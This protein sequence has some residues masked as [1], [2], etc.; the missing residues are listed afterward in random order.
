MAIKSYL[1]R[2]DQCHLASLSILQQIIMKK[3]LY[4]F[5][6]LAMI[7]CHAEEI[8]EEAIN[9]IYDL[10]E[11]EILSKGACI[12][13]GVIFLHGTSKVIGSEA[14]AEE[15][16]EL[17]GL[18]RIYALLEEKVNWKN[19]QLGPNFRH[20][21]FENWRL[22]MN[23]KAIVNNRMELASYKDN[24]KWHY[25]SCYYVKDVEFS[26]Y[27]TGITIDSMMMDFR[28]KF[29]K[30][31]SLYYY[32]LAHSDLNEEWRTKLFHNMQTQLGK[33]FARMFFG[34]EIE[35]TSSDHITKTLDA[36]KKLQDTSSFFEM[37]NVAN[38]L[39]YNKKVCEL[40]S[41]KLLRQELPVCAEVI[42][43]CGKTDIEILPPQPPKPPQPP[44]QQAPQPLQQQPPQPQPFP[45]PPEGGASARRAQAKRH[46]G[47][48]RSESSSSHAG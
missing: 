39:P 30:V 46:R 42:R 16:A 34:M 29:D 23:V 28:K 8:S 22:V 5:I 17:N 40:L 18:D 1:H 27:T 11:K 2:F 44:Q 24:G 15:M 9:D 36:Y 4:C 48:F 31:N 19:K 37:I 12:Y 14:M 13:S 20:A 3:I 35:K 7:F 41:R 33:N 25:I 6:L 43:K 32:E 26:N 10:H 45:T 21:V 38:E 47:I